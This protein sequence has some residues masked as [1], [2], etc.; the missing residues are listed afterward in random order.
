M[1]G[2]KNIM[3]GICTESTLKPCGRPENAVKKWEVIPSYIEK[4]RYNAIF[5]QKI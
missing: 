2:L 4:C 5:G 1:Y 3:Y